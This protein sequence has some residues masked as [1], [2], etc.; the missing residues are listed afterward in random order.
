MISV[1][2][3]IILLLELHCIVAQLVAIYFVCLFVLA[4]RAENRFTLTKLIVAADMSVRIKIQVITLRA[5]FDRLI[6][7]DFD[8]NRHLLG[9]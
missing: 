3:F 8:R 4:F 7:I 9:T 1:V 6:D 5:F 2:S